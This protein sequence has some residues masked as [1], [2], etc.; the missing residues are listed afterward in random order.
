MKSILSACVC[1]FLAFGCTNQVNTSSLKATTINNAI[2][3]LGIFQPTNRQPEP[4]PIFLP[5][6]LQ[7]HTETLAA[8]IDP[9]NI[10]IPCWLEG[11]PNQISCKDSK[12]P[13][14]KGVCTAIKSPI[15]T[16]FSNYFNI[17]FSQTPNT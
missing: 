8:C 6:T 1:T 17:I 4:F 7:E 5:L 16:Y 14:Q 11:D 3:P 9:G 15:N 12:Y 13:N 2:K 10:Q